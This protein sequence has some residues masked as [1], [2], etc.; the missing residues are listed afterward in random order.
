MGFRFQKRFTIAPGIRIN[1]SK[2]GVS[3]TV[4]P[5][6]ARVTF[7]RDKIRTTL[8]IPNTGLSHTE[9]HGGSNG[10]PLVSGIAALAI[11]VAIIVLVLSLI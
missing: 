8:G 7:G 1:L 2:T 4:G 10:P 5:R 11:L 3:T 9:I 6:G